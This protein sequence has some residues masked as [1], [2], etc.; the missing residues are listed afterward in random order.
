M[1]ALVLR[2]RLALLLGAVRG[3]RRHR[4]RLLVAL[5][6]TIVA[7]AALCVAIGWLRDADT[8]LVHVA[9]A[10]GG[11]VLVAGCF[12]A[13]LVTGAEDV[14][15]PRRFAVLGAEPRR[16]TL[17]L[18]AASLL[19]VSA[20]ALLAPAVCL[21]MLWIAHGASPVATIL[22]VAAGV[23]TCLLATRIA[24]AIGTLTLRHRRSR[25]LT[26]VLVAAVLA[27]VVPTVLFLVSQP[28][29][30]GVPPAV[31]QLV[32]VLSLS[33][34]GA[35]WAIPG[36]DVAPWPVLV[37]IVTLAGQIVLWGWLV[38]RLL[39]TVERPSAPA[40]K[41]GLGWFAVTAGTPVGAIAARSLVYWL[42]DPRYLANVVMVPVAGVLTALPLVVV[43]VRPPLAALLAVM[44]TALL[45]GWIA[46]NDLAY[47]ASALW[48]HVA[49]GVSGVA[50][51][52][53]RLAPAVTIGAPLL[54]VAIPVAVSMHGS[55]EILPAVVGACACLFL[56]GLGLS[57]VT[58]VLLPYVVSSPGDGP[59][60]Q[61]QRSRGGG[62]PAVVLF[63]TLL[64]S[65]PTL[66][67]AWH[68]LT[69][70]TD[71]MAALWTGIGTGAVVFI[72]G[73]A[74]GAALFTRR[75]GVLMEFAESM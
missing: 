69:A 63:G 73:V 22:A 15:D 55:W 30:G 57:S 53:G 72:A 27:V 68:A 38:R 7:V 54:A 10:L 35:A 49:A 33:P 48:M 19:G 23:A 29:A 34:L 1:A 61:P 74:I 9:T 47:D 32:D 40:S 4:M 3:D 46:H 18:A 28:W 14:L 11:A 43:G 20:W 6:A 66:W 16:L 2:L 36:T 59:F 21:V 5:I 25:E 31:E 45:F 71:G 70:S 58:S 41:G 64:L 8:L 13:P 62:G 65:A 37:T 50:D 42:R 52:L 24:Q 39:S 17:V 75:Q 67:L 56:C 44:V 12:A 60:Q 26:A 51:R